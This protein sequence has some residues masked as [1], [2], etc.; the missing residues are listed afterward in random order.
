MGAEITLRIGQR[1]GTFNQL[2]ETGELEFQNESSIEVAL[3]LYADNNADC[4]H[5][6][7]A[8][9]GERQPLVTFDRKASRVASA[10]PLE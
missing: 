10:L 7:S 5:I 8:H 4:L 3:N 9:V 6:A 1:D 2:R